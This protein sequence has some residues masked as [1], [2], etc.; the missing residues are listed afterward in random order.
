MQTDYYAQRRYALLNLI[1]HLGSVSRKKLAQLTD[2][3]PST[4]SDLCN[5]LIE[6]GFVIEAGHLAVGHGRRRVLLEINKA[7]LCAIGLSFSSSHLTFLVTQFDG[8]ILYNGELP[9]SLKMPRDELTHQILEQISA[10]LEQFSDRSFVGLGIGEPLYGPE[11]YSGDDHT[12]S[13]FTNWLK[14]DLRHALEQSLQFPI[15]CFNAVMLPALVEQRFG[16]AQGCQDFFCVELSNGIGCSI[17]CNGKV[18]SGSTGMA[19]ELGHVAI[20]V[21]GVPERPCYCGKTGCVERTSAFPFIVAEISKALEQG[22][23]SELNSFYDRSMPMRAQDIRRALDKGDQ[24]CMRVVK[25]AAH[26]IGLAIANS[27]TLL[28]PEKVI[29]YGFMLELGDFFVNEIKTSIYENVFILSR[30]FEL[31]VSQRLEAILP[32]GAAAEMFIKFLHAKDYS[33]VY[34]IDSAENS[35]EVDTLKAD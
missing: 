2:Y 17:C 33:W 12:Y 21:N 30:N 29:L 31:C 3:R 26:R 4:V 14:N 9:F 25:K 6:Q 8:E 11:F 7:Y 22:V 28:N 10:L 16:S 13:D 35:D 32:Q 15:N 1:Y 23:Y 20:E 27:I 24:L 19:G 34:K 5:E 18:V